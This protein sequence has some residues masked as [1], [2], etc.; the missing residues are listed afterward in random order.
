ML[1]QLLQV[2][3]QALYSLVTNGV[4]LLQTISIYRIIQTSS[5]NLSNRLGNWQACLI[6]GGLYV[7]SKFD[8][9]IVLLL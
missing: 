5:A 7:V 9:L 1:A 3:R 8:E 2:P 4:S 6:C